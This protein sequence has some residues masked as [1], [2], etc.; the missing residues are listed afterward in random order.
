MTPKETKEAGTVMLAAKYDENGNA[1]NIEAK[2]KGVNS[3]W[4]G[5]E[6]PVWD[7]RN[8]HYRILPSTPEAKKQRQKAKT[9]KKDR[10]P[11]AKIIAKQQ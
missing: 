5:C 2:A 11:T 8:F 3:F 1:L 4:F 10:R 6:N 9:Q 7:W